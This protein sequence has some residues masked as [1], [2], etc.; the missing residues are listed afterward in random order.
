MPKRYRIR[1]YQP[2]VL[3][4]YWGICDPGD[5]PELV[6][7]GLKGDAGTLLHCWNRREIYPPLTALVMKTDSAPSF[8]QELEDRGYDLTTIRFSIKKKPEMP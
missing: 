1:L 7:N 8:M 5:R 4:A 6:A 3:R 2:G